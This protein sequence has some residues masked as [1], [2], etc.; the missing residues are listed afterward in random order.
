MLK[1]FYLASNLKA[2]SEKKRF[3]FLL[4]TRLPVAESLQKALINFPAKKN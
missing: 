2:V 3:L 4:I 1:C